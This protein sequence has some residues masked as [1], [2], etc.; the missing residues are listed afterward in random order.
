MAAWPNSVTLNTQFEHISAATLSVDTMHVF[1]WTLNFFLSLVFYQF[2]YL[3]IP[4][5][6]AA[7]C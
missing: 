3:P 5:H 6:Q 7:P 4:N 2:G 1:V